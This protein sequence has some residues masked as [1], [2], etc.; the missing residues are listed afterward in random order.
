LVMHILATFEKKTI[1]Y[2]MHMH[3]NSAYERKLSK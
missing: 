1:L 2:F 3:I